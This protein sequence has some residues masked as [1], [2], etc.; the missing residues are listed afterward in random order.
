MSAS[1]VLRILS[2]GGGVTLQDAGRRGYM[3][4]GITPAG[5]MDPLAHAAANR[6]WEHIFPMFRRQLG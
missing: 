2:A 4:Y 5:P 6:D 3:R 1:A